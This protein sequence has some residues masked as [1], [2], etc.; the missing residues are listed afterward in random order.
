[1]TPT[2]GATLVELLA[3]SA[4]SRG[5]VTL[6]HTMSHHETWTMSDLWRQAERSAHV[7][8][9]LTDSDSVGVVLE[10]SPAS[11]ATLFA[12]WIA[13]FRVVSLP[14]APRGSRASPRI[15]GIREL[16]PLDLV[17]APPANHEA[18]G[19]SFARVMTAEDVVSSTVRGTVRQNS[20]GLVQYTSGSIGE[21][22]GV[23]LTLCAIASNVTDVLEVIDPSRS[24]RALSWLPLHHDMGLIGMLLAS[25]VAHGPRFAGIGHLTLVNTTVFTRDPRAWLRLCSDQR[26]TITAGPNAAYDIAARL[27]GRSLDLSMLRIALVGAEPVRVSTLDNFAKRFGKYGFHSA[28]L[29]PAYGLAEATLAVTMSSPSEQWR[30]VQ[31]PGFQGSGGHLV[32]GCGKTLSRIKARTDRPDAEVGQILIDGPSLLT[33]YTGERNAPRDTGYLATGDLGFFDNGELFVVGRVDDVLVVHGQKLYPADIEDQ[34]SAAL[35]VPVATVAAVGLQ[36]GY[37]IVIEQRGRLRRMES[38]AIA[39]TASS[40]LTG[41]FPS[42][43]EVRVLPAGAIPRTTSGKTRRVIAR[44][45]LSS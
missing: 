26:A 15:A 4:A 40:A 16:E 29:C 28:A 31:T 36:D 45:L 3:E 27:S 22:S 42:P 32:V 11:I 30:A 25:L 5:T 23:E 37:A 39:Q 43:S 14:A 6:V 19:G 44:Q 17:V 20:G 34:V 2:T 12:A 35:D 8:A 10:P 38:V 9:G 13:G 41:I 21:P 18:L 33:R 24:D 1:M 7:L